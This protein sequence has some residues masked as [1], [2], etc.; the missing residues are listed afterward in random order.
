MVQNHINE[1]KFQL[2]YGDQLNLE[3]FEDLG[4]WKLGDHMGMKQA[5]GILLRS[6]E[7]D[8]MVSL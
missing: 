8:R 1:L 3:M 6:R 5:I 7:P 4:P 2:K